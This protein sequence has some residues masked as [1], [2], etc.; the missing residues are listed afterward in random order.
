LVYSSCA[1]LNPDSSAD[2][3]MIDEILA[4][5]RQCNAKVDVTGALLFTEGRFVQ[6]LEGDRN[7]V[8]AT[9]ER[10]EADPRH[11]NVE[12]LSSQFGDRRRFKQWSMAFVGDNEALRNRFD[13]SPLAELGKKP[14]GDAL[15][16]FMLELARCTDRTSQTH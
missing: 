11:A 1:K 4:N 5:A 7:D 12:I 9:Y 3:A 15:L 2:L 16:D 10:I 6:A 8:R 13:D 14:A